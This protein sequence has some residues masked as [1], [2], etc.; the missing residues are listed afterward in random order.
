MSPEERR[1]AVLTATV[2]LLR[3]RGAGVS[4]RDLAR[5]AGVAEGTLFRVFPDKRAL[6]RAALAE[7]L[8]PAALEKGLAAVDRT[9]PLEHRVRRVVELLSERMDGLVQLLTALH[10]VC[11]DALAKG[12]AGS[13]GAEHDERE[14]RVLA[15]V[16]AVLEPDATDLR[17]SP[18]QAA[19][20]VRGAVLG[21]RMPGLATAARLTPEELAACLTS[22]LRGP[23]PSGPGLSAPGRPVPHGAS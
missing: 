19:A 12:P 6:L 1:A 18:S 16:A 20:L 3:E 4:T 21:D 8:D 13:L 5:A 9:L 15:S 14:A 17:V 7:A 10:D 11:G 22:G 2:P 23:G